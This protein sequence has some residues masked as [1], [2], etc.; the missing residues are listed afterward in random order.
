MIAKIVSNEPLEL[1]TFA[2]FD[3]VSKQ[4]FPLD[5]K[6]YANCIIGEIFW[7]QKEVEVYLEGIHKLKIGCD[8]PG[9]WRRRMPQYPG[10]TLTVGNNGYGVWCDPMG[11]HPRAILLEQANEIGQVCYVRMI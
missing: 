1:H 6:H 2:C 5:N 4:V 8:D 9:S 3:W 7:D 10:M 11:N